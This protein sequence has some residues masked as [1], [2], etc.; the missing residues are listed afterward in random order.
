M[1]ARATPELPSKRRTVR[2]SRPVSGKNDEAFMAAR[3]DGGTI[4]LG[5]RFAARVDGKRLVWSER[6][7]FDQQGVAHGVRHSVWATGPQGE[8]PER[9][10]D[11]PD[12]SPPHRRWT[13]GRARDDLC[14]EGWTVGDA[15]AIAAVRLIVL[16]PIGPSGDRIGMGGGTGVLVRTFAPFRGGTGLLYGRAPFTH[17]LR[18]LFTACTVTVSATTEPCY[19]R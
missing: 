1:T 9:M 12:R 10:G 4:F 8:E 19:R 18:S 11:E 2:V 13:A 14:S 17:G 6:L 15:P 3:A 7:W 16:S 5:L